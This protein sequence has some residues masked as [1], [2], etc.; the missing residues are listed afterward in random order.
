MPDPSSS[1]AVQLTY[2]GH[3]TLLIEQDGVRIITD[4][5]FRK[6]VAFLR[7]A[8]P[9]VDPGHYR[10][11]TAVLISHLHYDHLDF[12]SLKRIGTQTPIIAPRGAAPLLAKKGFRNCQELAQ[13][14]RTRVGPF[15]VRATPADHKP[16]RGPHGPEAD[17]L[18]YILQGAIRVYFPGD[19]QLFP[20][21]AELAR[22]EHGRG[23]DVAFLPVWGWGPR[24]GDKH[25]DPQEAARA[26]TL[27]CPRVAIPIH[28][29]TY[30]P[31]G[32]GWL[33]LG[34]Q[35]LPPLDFERN[36]KHLAPQ[37]EVCILRPGEA[38]SVAPVSEGSG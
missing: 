6:Q 12:P 22:D 18:G 36:A 37:V 11:I 20:G 1:S 10:A 8:G 38:I 31:I 29:G 28:W 15:E 2:L 19:T 4:P 33:R 9:P 17:P 7:R 34:F 14:D 30:F 13:S 35:Y 25:L 32:F 16:Q 5:L 21:M 3:S 23:L 24:L 27:L 26:L